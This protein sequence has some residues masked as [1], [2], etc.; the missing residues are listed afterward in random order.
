MTGLTRI[1]T[2]ASTTLLL[3]ACSSDQARG[4]Q[5]RGS[6][7]H[8]S[9][10][11]AQS[12]FTGVQ[13]APGSGDIFFPQAR[14]GGP[15]HPIDGGPKHASEDAGPDATT[16]PDECSQDR[17]C[18]LLEK[19]C[20]GT[21]D[22]KLADVF[23]VPVGT[24]PPPECG[25]AECGACPPPAWDAVHAQLVASCWEGHCWA[26]DLRTMDLTACSADADCELRAA[27][28][29][30][31]CG[32]GLGGWLAL[33]K[34]AP[35]DRASCDLTS[36]CPPCVATH[37]PTAF[38]AADKHCALRDP[39][40]EQAQVSS[41]CFSPFQNLD[42]A[43]DSNAQGCDCWP[44]GAQV[45]KGSSTGTGIALTCKNQRWTAVVDASCLFSPPP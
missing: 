13:G 42:H 26:Q 25:T 37:K 5:N 41:T 3:L 40:T 23:A 9:D 28:C 31:S 1:G 12:S 4:A 18:T 38:C 43:Y 35:N 20:C 29:C 16:P 21:C 24:P 32:Y 10:G 15:V 8:G 6:W 34:D 2:F 45:C 14:D 7:G 30:E 22:A 11:G 33:R 36:A 19:G 17:D 39:P 27:G 44:E